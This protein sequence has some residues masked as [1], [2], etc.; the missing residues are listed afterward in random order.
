MGTNLSNNSLSRR[1]FLVGLGATGALAAAGSLAACASEDKGN[2]VADDATTAAPEAKP[3]ASGSWRDKPSPITDIAETLEADIVVVGAGNGG[4]AAATTAIQAG[5]KVIVVQKDA[6][7]GRG[8]EAVGALNSSMAGEH[9]EDVVTLLNHA[10]MVQSGDAN[11]LM[12]KTWAEKSGEMIEWMADTLAPKD[13]VF[14]FEWH[15]PEGT[16]YP[17][18]CYNPIKGEYNPDGP[19]YGAYEHLTALSE[20]FLEE[21]GGIL[22]ETPGK[23]LVQDSSGKVTGVIAESKERGMIQI[24]AS[25]GVVIAT[26]GY[27]ANL[28]MLD[29]F[30]PIASQACVSGSLSS[31]TQ[32]GDGIKMVLW[33]GGIMEEGGACMIWNRGLMKEDTEFGQPWQGD[34]FTP[35]SQPFLRVNAHGERFM[36]EDQCYPMNFAGALNQPGRFAWMIWDSK[37]WEDMVRFDTCGCSRL[38]PA[39]SGTAFNADIFDLEALTE[40]HLDSFWM[41]PR[42]ENG[43]LKRCDTL[44]ELA[45]AMGFTA[46][47]TDTFIAT[48]ERYNELNDSGVDSDFGKDAF[49]MSSISEPPYYAAKLAGNLLAT[50]NGVVTDVNGQPINEAGDPIEGLYVCGNDQ[51]GFY[52]HNYPSNFTGINVGRS[53]TFGRIAAKHALDIA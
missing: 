39:P 42:V 16:Y 13:F 27:S 7:I 43:F 48:V 52:P 5:A 34:T 18:M 41:E 17:A 4:L 50:I 2:A 40:E 8:R 31:N 10:N 49:R 45:E 22:F 1:G 29:E 3:E 28:E 51:G 46:E 36:N 33:A 37:Y 23:Q 26:G 38:T 30:A 44:E 24:N 21:G 20:V 9:Q 25:K 32:E 35:G 53:Y 15:C 47:Q 11:M 6:G 12:Y 19:N 14:P